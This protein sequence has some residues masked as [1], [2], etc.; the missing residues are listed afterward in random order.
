MNKFSLADYSFIIKE[1]DEVGNYTLDEAKLLCA[2]LGNCWR[3]PKL[4]E[5]EL[6]YNECLV[7]RISKLTNELKFQINKTYYLTDTIDEYDG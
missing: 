4:E 1:E 6:V 7:D 3:V 5:L 2:N